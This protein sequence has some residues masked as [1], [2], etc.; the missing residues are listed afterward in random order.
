[1]RLAQIGVLCSYLLEQC[2]K[3]RRHEYNS[4]GIKDDSIVYS[5]LKVVVLGHHYICL[6]ICRALTDE[7]RSALSYP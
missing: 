1:M 6:A 3:K 4:I 7:D 5:R 2:E